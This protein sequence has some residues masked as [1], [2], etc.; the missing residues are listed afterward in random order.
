M[1]LTREQHGR[2]RAL[3]EFDRRRARG[4]GRG[5]S[6]NDDFRDGDVFL[7]K[8]DRLEPHRGLPD[9]ALFADIDRFPCRVL[10]WRQSQVRMSH[11]RNDLFN[12]YTG[13]LPHTVCALDWLHTLSLGCFQSYLMMV[14]NQFVQRDAWSTGAGDFESKLVISSATWFA[15]MESWVR[16]QK[17]LP[18]R[19]KLT[20][21]GK[22][23]AGALGSATKPSFGFKGAETNTILEYVVTVLLAR[24]TFP[25]LFG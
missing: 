25:C 8:G 16:G 12:R 14:V 4:S 17:K 10:F 24:P 21:V 23:K 7:Q 22:F 9:V 3:L 11:H 20:E 15:D 18:G 2:V 5:W 1:S 13:I 19:S 6:L